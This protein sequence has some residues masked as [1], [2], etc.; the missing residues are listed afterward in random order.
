MCRARV[1]CH[2]CPRP[3]TFEMPDTLKSARYA[4]E[5][6]APTITNATRLTRNALSMPVCQIVVRGM[7]VNCHSVRLLVNRLIAESMLPPAWRIMLGNTE[8]VAAAN[9]P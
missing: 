5:A 1:D 4:T 2:L 7:A 8:F 9:K 6:A 3:L